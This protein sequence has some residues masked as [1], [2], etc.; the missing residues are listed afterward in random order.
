MTSMGPQTFPSVLGLSGQGTDSQDNGTKLMCELIILS[1]LHSFLSVILVWTPDQIRL[2]LYHHYTATPV[3][4]PY[5]HCAGATAAC[6]LR[7]PSCSETTG[8]RWRRGKPNICRIPIPAYLPRFQYRHFRLL[9]LFFITY[10]WHWATRTTR[11]ARCAA[12]AWAAGRRHSAATDNQAAVAAFHAF[13]LN[14]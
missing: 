6:H 2:C 11:I 5:A 13:S 3:P 14:N 8:S 9:P 4:L 1:I 7:L 12:G 10:Y